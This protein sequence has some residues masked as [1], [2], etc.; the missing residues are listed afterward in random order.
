M[1]TIHHATKEETAAHFSDAM[2]FINGLD[3]LDVHNKDFF[4]EQ[5]QATVY[6]LHIDNGKGLINF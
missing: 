2:L 3:F 6:A 1:R 5:N 4:E